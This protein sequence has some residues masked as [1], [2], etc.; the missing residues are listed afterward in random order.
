LIFT[1]LAIVFLIGVAAFWIANLGSVLAGVL[2]IVFTLLGILI[3]FLQWRPQPQLAPELYA[4][5]ISA[6]GRSQHFYE[7]VEGIMLEASKR[8]GALVVYTRKDLRGSSINL[9]FGFHH[10]HSKVDLASSVIGRRRKGSIVYI[11]VFSLLEP[12]NYMVHTDSQ[13]LVTKVSV[14][15]GRVVEVDWR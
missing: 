13:E 14:S 15:P 2:S 10:N 7:Q 8:K 12:G 9:S 6:N 11:A 1:G 4:G 3:A 5:E